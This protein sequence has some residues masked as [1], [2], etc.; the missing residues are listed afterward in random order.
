MSEQCALILSADK[1]VSWINT[2]TLLS[3][4]RTTTHGPIRLE[5]RVAGEAEQTTHKAVMVS[6]LAVNGLLPSTT[7]GN[8]STV[9]I[10]PHLT[11]HPARATVLDSKS[12]S[13]G[14]TK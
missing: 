9:S 3:V 1:V 4:P 7:A 12:G 11:R 6:S 13:T 2:R 5:Q 14:M 10:L 8:G